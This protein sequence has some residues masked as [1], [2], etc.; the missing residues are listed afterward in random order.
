MANIAQIE[1][2]KRMPMD[3]LR[4]T[5]LMAGVLYLVTIVTSI[6]ALILYGPVLN[7]QD[8]IVGPGPDTGV[9]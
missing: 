2:M 4:K 3:S 7:N 8:F 1:E 5:A 9:L 6:P